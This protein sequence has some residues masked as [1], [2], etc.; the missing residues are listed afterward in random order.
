M[1]FCSSEWT[2][3][4]AHTRYALH[5][6]LH[7]FIHAFIHCITNYQILNDTLIFKSEFC[8]I[9]VSLHPVYLY[10]RISSLSCFFILY[11]FQWI[12]LWESPD[13]LLSLGEGK[14]WVVFPPC[15][16]LFIH[17]NFRLETQ[18]PKIC[19]YGCNLE[20]LWAPVSKLRAR[21]GDKSPE[22]F[23]FC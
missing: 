23:T 3:I 12:N 19:R 11:S 4:A 8:A 21:H 1:S 13:D 18:W 16:V 17:F 15:S 5:S 2:V 7:L 20:D 14:M 10:P 9:F 22:E 6:L